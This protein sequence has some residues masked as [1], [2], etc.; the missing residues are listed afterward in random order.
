MED[1]MKAAKTAYLNDA[2]FHARVYRAV[3]L[4][5]ADFHEQ[6][7]EHLTD[8]DRHMATHA[9]SLALVMD[10]ATVTG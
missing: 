3:T 5:D 10:E 4:L 6:T 7:G 2:M 1:V 8:R 9:A